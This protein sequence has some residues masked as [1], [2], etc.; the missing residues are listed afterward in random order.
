MGKEKEMSSGSETPKENQFLA[1]LSAQGSEKGELISVAN[2][3]T[4]LMALSTHPAP[5]V[6]SPTNRL[7][8]LLSEPVLKHSLITPY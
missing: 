3:P 7:Q 6:M 4:G 2:S 5:S 1:L 8:N